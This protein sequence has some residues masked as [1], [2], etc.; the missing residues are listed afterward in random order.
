MDFSL[1]KLAGWALGDQSPRE[2]L[3]TL[4]GDIGLPSFGVGQSL[5]TTFLTNDSGWS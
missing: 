5:S 4:A 2:R 1:Q 3:I